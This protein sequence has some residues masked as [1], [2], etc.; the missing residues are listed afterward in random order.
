[1]HS[2]IC[3]GL[4]E[5]TKWRCFSIP[6]HS[7]GILISPVGTYNYNVKLLVTLGACSDDIVVLTVH[8]DDYGIEERGASVG[9]RPTPL[10]K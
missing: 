5:F 8:M 1:M 3:R 4:H 7:Q 9:Y 10:Y 2:S 6:I